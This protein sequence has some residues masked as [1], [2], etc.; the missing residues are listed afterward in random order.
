MFDKILS[1]YDT[2]DYDFKK[3]ANPHDELEYLFD[4]WL[5]MYRMKYAICKALQPKTILEIGVGY[6][7]SAITFLEASPAAFYFGIDN[8]TDTY[9]GSKGAINWAKQITQDYNAYFLISDT[10]RMNNLPGI[11]YDLIHIE[12]KQEGDRTFHNLELALSKATWILVE[13]YFGLKENMFSAT[14]FIKKYSRHIEYAHIIP[15]Y[16]G[17]LLLKINESNQ[18]QNR[19]RNA[20]HLQIHEYYSD[21]YFNKDCGGFD[22]FKKTH[23]RKLEDIRLMTAF[24]LSEPY[25]G[26]RILDIGC[27]RG[28][29]SY[30]LANAGANITGI[31]YSESA[32]NIAKAAFREVPVPGK[33][34][35]LCEDAINFKFGNEKYDVILA[36]DFVEHVDEA[37]LRKILEKSTKALS[38]EGHLIIHTAPNRDYYDYYYPILRQKARDAGAYIPD[39]PRSY[40][41]D[42]VHI[43]EQS[44]SDLEILLKEYFH[45]VIVWVAPDS[46][47]SG[48]L[49]MDY[50]DETK[51][52]MRSIYA[53]ASNSQIN[54]KDLYNLLSQWPISSQ[55]LNVELNISNIPLKMD[56]GKSYDI[57]VCLTNSGDQRMVSLQ[58]Y[59]VHLSYHWEDK[60]CN[61]S[62]FEGIRTPIFPPLLSGEKRDFLM[63]VITPPESGEYILQLTLVQEKVRWFE[64][65]ISSLPLCIECVIN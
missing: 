58:P 13:G 22:L 4:E 36:T 37:A 32:I 51:H 31:D 8:D 61:I 15:G 26:K 25:L 24:L 40:Y 10:Q 57:S 29:L 52:S 44:P 53:V 14:Q 34:R 42:L 7:Y 3:Y 21:E 54:P 64:E 48:S 38:K 18:Y 49:N 60:K 50:T 23:G 2:C 33:L 62:I 11:H 17:E 39:N 35:F 19:V 27:G 28:E 65:V 43:N 55:K 56:F 9:G 63:N 1:I 5:P 45:Y 20:D 47:M 46:E 16:S 6:G 41:E 59:P 30:A 12:E